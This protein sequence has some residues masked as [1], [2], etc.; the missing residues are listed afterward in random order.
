[1]RGSPTLA[2]DV[3]DHGGGATGQGGG[4]S[5]G[6][7]VGPC[8]LGRGIGGSW[9]GVFL[10]VKRFGTVGSDAEIEIEIEVG[11]HFSIGPREGKERTMNEILD[12]RT[13]FL[14]SLKGKVDWK[15]IWHMLNL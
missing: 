5:G 11:I 15:I 14:V 10:V 6:G 7:S 8:G 9:F 4:L 2:E 1:M 12:S 13:L 3:S